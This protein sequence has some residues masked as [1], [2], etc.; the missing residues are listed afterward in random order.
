MSNAEK[1]R[2]DVPSG[3]FIQIFE[4]FNIESNIKT[5]FR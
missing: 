3:F 5:R 4:C 2:L 1:C